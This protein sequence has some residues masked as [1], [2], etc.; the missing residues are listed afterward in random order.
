M[1]RVAC[2]FRSYVRL[3]SDLFGC[4]VKARGA[5]NA[6]DIEQSHARHAKMGADSGEFLGQGSALEKA[7]CRAGVKFD[8]H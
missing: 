7:E 3:E 2:D 5:I 4:Q 8:I 6:V 1:E